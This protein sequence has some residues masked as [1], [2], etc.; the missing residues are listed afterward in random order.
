MLRV[1]Q[2]CWDTF[3]LLEE[4]V[5]RTN[6]IYPDLDPNDIMHWLMASNLHFNPEVAYTKDTEPKWITT[7]K[8]VCE[9]ERVSKETD[10]RQVWI[11]KANRGGGKVNQLETSSTSLSI[12]TE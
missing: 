4:I 3:P 5:I 2:F 9:L 1:L 12:K 7:A 8:K 10:E 6:T 11:W